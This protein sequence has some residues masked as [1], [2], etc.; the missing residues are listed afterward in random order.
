VV[1]FTFSESNTGGIRSRRFSPRSR[2]HHPTHNLFV[3]L[4]P[5]L[6]VSGRFELKLIE[7]RA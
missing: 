3:E 4:V 5:G 2:V 6:S 1:N 7:E